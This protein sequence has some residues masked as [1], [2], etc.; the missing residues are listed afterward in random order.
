MSNILRSYSQIANQPSITFTVGGDGNN[1]K[2]VF[3]LPI[4]QANDSNIE[5]GKTLH[6]DLVFH[7]DVS[8]GGSSFGTYVNIN[9]VQ[10][11]PG[12]GPGLLNSSTSPGRLTYDIRI[13]FID[14]TT[15]QIFQKVW[16]KI[17]FNTTSGGSFLYTAPFDRTVDNT[18]II[19]S[20]QY[21][22]AA[23]M[24]LTPI[25]TNIYLQ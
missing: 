17:E 21:T 9:G 23:D 19:E 25:A 7:Y 14:A 5:D 8:S 24:V 1:F 3:T 22:I 18:I 2:P 4:I 11:G 6:I 12:T 15:V 13:K 10:Y 20:A 16:K